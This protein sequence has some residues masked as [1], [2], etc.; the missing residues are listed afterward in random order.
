MEVRALASS[1]TTVRVQAR[2]FM[3]VVKVRYGDEHGPHNLYRYV[4]Y[5]S[6]VALRTDG[7]V[8]YVYWSEAL[9]HVD[10]WLLAYDLA[11]RREIDRRRVDPRDIG[12]IKTASR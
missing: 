12:G 5:S 10:T 11:S 6:P 9:I 2:D 8:L 4:D 7:D 3:D 1:G